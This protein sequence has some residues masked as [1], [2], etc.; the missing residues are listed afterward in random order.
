MP[1]LS[2]RIPRARSSK[3]VGF[4]SHHLGVELGL[5]IRLPH[6]KSSAKPES[7]F[8]QDYA[9]RLYEEF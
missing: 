7:L 3:W 5:S 9:P 2:M 8:H 4:D 1:G 6:V